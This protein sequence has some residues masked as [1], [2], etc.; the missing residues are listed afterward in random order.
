MGPWGVR[1]GTGQELI[2]NINSG[3]AAVGQLGPALC[4]RELPSEMI[5]LMCLK[6]PGEACCS[7]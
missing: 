3:R 5:E 6:A 1:V 7:Y 2:R 4:S